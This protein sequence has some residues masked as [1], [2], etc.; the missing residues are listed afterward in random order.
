MGVQIANAG[1]S[2]ATRVASADR[3][4]PAASAIGVPPNAPLPDGRQNDRGNRAHRDHDLPDQIR[5]P[6]SV[7]GEPA[8]PARG[9]HGLTLSPDPFRWQPEPLPDR[10][11]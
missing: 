3:T 5:R 11:G 1:P 8:Q 2:G 7:S 6:G 10:T 4:P 9:F